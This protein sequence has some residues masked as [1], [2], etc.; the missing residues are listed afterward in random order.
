[1]QRRL[2]AHLAGDQRGDLAEEMVELDP[3]VYT[4]PLRFEAERRM[5]FQQEPLLAAFS[6]ELAEPGDRVLFDAAGPP[7]VVIRGT[8]RKLRAFLNMCTHRG[9]RLVTDCAPGKRLLCPFH[10]WAFD[11]EGRLAGMPLSAAFEGMDREARGL[12]RVP[13]G[14]WGGMVFVRASPG[15]EEVDVEGFLGPIA[16]LLEALELGSLRKIRADRLD[17]RANWKLALD[18]GREV[19]HVP[20]V[21]RNTLAPNLH[22]T[23][24]LFDCFGPHNRFSGAS[25]DFEALVDRPEEEWPW[26]SYQAVHY[27]F[28]STTLSFTHSVDGET[29][30]VTM[31]RVFP[32]ESIG[33]AMTLMATYRRGEADSATD[34]QI[35]VMHEAV[36]GIVGTEDYGAAAN[37]WRTIEH[38]EAMPRL[39][40][41]RNE[42]F[43]QRYHRDVAERIGMPLP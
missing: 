6:E 42:L 32:G 38:G 21:H 40:L 22:P 33:E 24:A 9:A 43:V 3:R 4:D 41:G 8:D 7:I 39:V 30:V 28:P 18:M 26:M 34:E 17:V 25:S 10:G 11:L 23:V 2:V 27:L 19:Y 31:S 36:L 15:E 5:I 1:M 37:V 14:E 13:V 20:V 16:P 29:P 35:G 12:V